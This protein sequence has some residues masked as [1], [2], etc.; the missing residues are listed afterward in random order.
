MN[1]AV[2]WFQ[3]SPTLG[4]AALFANRMQAQAGDELFDV[5]VVFT[6][7]RGRA[8]PLG[9]LGRCGSDVDQHGRQAN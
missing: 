1:V 2:R 4:Q 8:Q 5:L 7:R 3:H 6:G 9:P